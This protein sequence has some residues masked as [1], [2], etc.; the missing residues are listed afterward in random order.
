VVVSGSLD[1][2]GKE[3]LVGSSLWKWSSAFRCLVVQENRDARF[4]FIPSYELAELFR[5]LGVRL[6][7]DH[8]YCEEDGGFSSAIWSDDQ[9]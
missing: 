6:T 4:L 1:N 2:S 8:G 3:N 7:E 9:I 5:P